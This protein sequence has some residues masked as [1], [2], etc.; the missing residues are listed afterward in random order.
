MHALQAV[1]VAVKRLAFVCCANKHTALLLAQLRPSG[2]K[3]LKRTLP[4]CPPGED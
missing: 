1:A 2:D 4:V 3:H